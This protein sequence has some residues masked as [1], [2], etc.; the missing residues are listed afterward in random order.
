M[1]NTEK[2]LELLKKVFNGLDNA[3]EDQ[4]LSEWLESDEG[5]K[6]F[7]SACKSRWLDATTA[8]D[9]DIADE[10]LGNIED[11]TGMDFA[12]QKSSIP[13]IFRKIAAVLF[14]VITSS[15]LTYLWSQHHSA[16]LA[17]AEHY[18]TTVNR[19]QKA[20]ITLPDGSEVWLNSGTKFY[21][22]GNYDNKDRRVYLEGEAYF[23]VAKNPG[24]PFVVACNGMSVKALGTAF[25][26]RG[27]QEES[28]VIASLIQGKVE[29][30]ADNEREIL[31]PNDQVIFNVK[32]GKV[33]RSK[34]TDEREAAAWMRDAFYFKNTPLKE[35]AKEIERMYGTPII[36][37][38]E[39]IGDI[40]F[41]GSITNTGMNNIL[42]I[43]SMTYPLDYRIKD[44][45]VI[46]S[47]RH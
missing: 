1:N 41:S 22:T 37:D 26:V 23:K 31:L 9:G 46:I 6:E 13:L 16:Q 5:Q 10:I 38:T 40:T 19:G 47:E 30:T 29:V 12:K 18:V 15:A 34:F 35:I 3:D 39:N 43:I 24:K 45:V 7:D 17:E 42:H 20:K 27:Y 4:Q 14:F 21:Y 33:E 11:E 36:F 2:N 32:S 28:T 25:T 44:G 8:I